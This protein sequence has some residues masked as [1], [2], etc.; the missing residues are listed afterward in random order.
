MALVP[1]RITRLLRLKS[2]AVDFGM[3][4][5]TVISSSVATSTSPSVTTER[6]SIDVV[7]VKSMTLVTYR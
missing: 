7:E 1:S 2:G 4:P 3:V 5:S 6:Q